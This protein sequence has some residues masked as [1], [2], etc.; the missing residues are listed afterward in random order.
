MNRESENAERN[1]DS[2]TDVVSNKVAYYF[3]TQAQEVTE[4]KRTVYKRA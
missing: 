1:A 4:P 2:E 3:F